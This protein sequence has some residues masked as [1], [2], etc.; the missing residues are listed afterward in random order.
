MD[1][2]RNVIRGE[3]VDGICQHY[4][5]VI[6]GLVNAY[7]LMFENFDK[8][9]SFDAAAR[10]NWCV[11]HMFDDRAGKL[12]TGSV[13][14]SGCEYE[15][16]MS[17][18]DAFDDIINTA[19]GAYEFSDDRAIFALL[20]CAKCQFFCDGNKRTAQVIANHILVH[21]NAGGMIVIPMDMASTFLDD[22]LDFYDGGITLDD[23]M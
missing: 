3:Y 6:G 21:D 22:L 16:P 13:Y 19:Y 11:E 18:I 14:I 2:A 17:T 12:R 23:A 10:Y 15:L 5:D 1:D 7:A 9:V 4:I 8:P 20:H